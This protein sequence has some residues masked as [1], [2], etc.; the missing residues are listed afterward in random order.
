MVRVPAVVMSGE[1]DTHRLRRR[2]A[3]PSDDARSIKIES[4]EGG[5]NANPDNLDE[6][7]QPI[8][9]N[10][11]YHVLSASDQFQFP[12]RPQSRNHSQDLADKV[13]CVDESQIQIDNM[14]AV[15][16]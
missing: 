11:I 6:M 14:V 13:L 5:S 4:P 2:D 7:S 12:D 16:G 9:H 8:V 10:S 3:R 1:K 15:I